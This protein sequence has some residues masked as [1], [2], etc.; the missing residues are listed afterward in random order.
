L[1]DILVV[2]EYGIGLRKRELAAGEGK[3][4]AR[5]FLPPF[6]WLVPPISP[7]RP[8]CPPPDAAPG[9]LTVD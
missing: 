3:Y 9:A 5:I 8:H 7:A 4:P 6:V 2:L 1:P